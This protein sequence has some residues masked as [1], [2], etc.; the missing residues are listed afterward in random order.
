MKVSTIIRL[1]RKL[2]LAI[3]SAPA[4]HCQQRNPNMELSQLQR[5][6]DAIP[7]YHE[8]DFGNGL[9][10][11]SR[12]AD[13]DLHRRFWRFIE[14]SLNTVDFQNKTVLDVGCWDGYW[15]FYAERH[16]AKSVLAT[17]DFSQ[18]WASEAGL[19]LARELLGSQ[20]QTQTRTSVYDL[21]SLGQKFDIVLMLGVYY[22]L[23]DPFYAFAQLR[24]CCHT[25]TVI[26]IEGNENIGLPPNT[27]GLDLG[28]AASKFHPTPGYLRQLLRGAYFSVASEKF[29][30]PP[31]WKP[32]HIPREWRRRMCREALFGRGSKIWTMASELVNPTREHLRKTRR[33]FLIC[34]PFEGEN[35]L[36]TYPPPF[37]LQ[38]FDSRFAKV[39]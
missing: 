12:T 28:D 16:G 31:P 22:H 15:S 26:C 10:A 35:P 3:S 21:A 11:R 34:N 1:R 37:G 2:E 39:Q 19:L 30:E 5:Q 8:F 27:A 23:V 29:L 20:I 33:A 17:D 38:T 25:E 9:Q 4:S 24:K 32:P 14:E 36:H 18:N 6:I 7:W 13:I